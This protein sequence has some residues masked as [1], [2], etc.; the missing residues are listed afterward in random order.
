MINNIISRFNFNQESKDYSI[1]CSNSFHL[2][3]L[4]GCIHA[5]HEIE[6]KFDVLEF[7]YVDT[8]AFKGIQN[9]FFELLKKSGV[10]DDKSG[11]V[12]SYLSMIEGLKSGLKNEIR[13][14]TKEWN[15][16]K[17][18]CDE[19]FLLKLHTNIKTE[20][21]S[22]CDD[23][24]AFLILR[25]NEFELHINYVDEVN[26]RIN[27]RQ[28][29]LNQQDKK[30]IAFSFVIAEELQTKILRSLKFLYSDKF[31][32]LKISSLV[33]FY[34]RVIT[35]SGSF[36]MNEKLVKEFTKI[37]EHSPHKFNE[38]EVEGFEINFNEYLG[39]SLNISHALKHLK[40]DI[41]NNLITTEKNNST[42]VD[43]FNKLISDDGYIKLDKD[44]VLTILSY[45]DTRVRE[46]NL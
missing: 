6:M 8:R 41:N 33:M 11:I 34:T 30:I 37:I 32:L 35:A 36:K 2:G 12:L 23:K 20:Y 28:D 31:L 40:K 16:D 14:L 3:Y 27:K 43:D 24:A 4:I 18:Y 25:K 10:K 22:L 42:L 39:F 19:L 26:S 45:L 46:F 29:L 1:Y 38:T 7:Q 21:L 15:N 13:G 9:K 17:K 5:N 44:N